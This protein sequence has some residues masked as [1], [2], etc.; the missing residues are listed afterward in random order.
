MHFTRKKNGL[1]TQDLAL[2]NKVLSGDE[3]AFHLFYNSYFPRIYRFCIARLDDEEAVRDV[4]QQ[5]MI[6]A[7]RSLAGYRAEAS[8]LTWLCQIAR[9]EMASWYSTHA[10]KQSRTVSF[11]DHPALRAA[12]ESLPSDLAGDELSP[13]QETLKNL[14]QMSLDSLPS[15]Y[16]VVLELKY[17]EGL[18]VAEIADQ[19][20]AGETAT[21]SLLARARNA[22]KEVFVDLQHQS[23]LGE[24]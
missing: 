10:D 11:E 9:N 3:T 6:R 4:V 21:Q 1:H 20:G 15:A 8:L 18:S 16:A 12:Y 24:L 22:F 7:M 5:S 13:L 19:M 23:A 17:I 2:A 14:V